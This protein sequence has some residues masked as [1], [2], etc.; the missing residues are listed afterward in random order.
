[1]VGYA[2]VKAPFY[3]FT[4]VLGFTAPQLDAIWRRIE[5]CKPCTRT[6]TENV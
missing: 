2:T 4:F 5:S 1:M 3:S 6:V